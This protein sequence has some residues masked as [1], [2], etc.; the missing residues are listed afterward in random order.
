MAVFN[1][2][3]TIDV[4]TCEDLMGWF[5]C[6]YLDL[7]ECSN[8][9]LLTVTFITFFIEHFSVA[10]S[11]HKNLLFFWKPRSVVLAAWHRGDFI[12]RRYWNGLFGLPCFSVCLPVHE[13]PQHCS[14]LFLPSFIHHLSGQGHHLLQSLSL[15][16]F[17]PSPHINQDSRLFHRL[18]STSKP[19][20]FLQSERPVITPCTRERDVRW[21]G[22]RQ[23]NR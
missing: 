10:P 8:S 22:G 20:H 21:V 13:L 7:F 11:R 4:T 12:F 6:F 2:Q 9:L 23:A 19:N 5:K 16:L 17:L 15:P 1:F 14:S 3:S 18:N